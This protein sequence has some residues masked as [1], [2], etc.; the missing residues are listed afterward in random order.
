MHKVVLPILLV[1]AISMTAVAQEAEAA[2]D[3]GVAGI[4]PT[5]MYISSDAGE[6]AKVE[7]G[8]PGIGDTCIVGEF[9]E[10][11]VGPLQFCTDVALDITSLSV[12]GTPELY[13]ITFTD[14]WKVD[15]LSGD[16]T[17]VG[18]LLDGIV[19]STSM[20]AL[21][22]DFGGIAYATSFSG[23][24]YQVDLTDG[25]LSFLK[26]LGSLHGTT[27]P[28]SGDLAWDSSTGKMYWTSTHCDADGL[29][30]SAPALCAGGVDGLWLI[31]LVGPF[32]AGY[33]VND[34][35]FIADLLHADV[36]AADFIPGS[37]NICYVNSAGTL[38]ETNTSG[39]QQ[40]AMATSPVVGAF[41][42][43]AN[44][45]LV[46]GIAIALDAVAM[47]I[48]GIQTSSIWMAPLVFAGIGFVAYKLRSKN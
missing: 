15:Q 38:F 24:F 39:V 7:T 43:S 25:S 19:Q 29:G 4:T 5:Q 27:L 33:A 3:C 13:C 28:S 36:F 10:A 14:L 34:P 31:H 9:R 32:P 47:V 26:N 17:F 22:I 35:E 16:L 42:G 40:K 23:N 44:T 18:N 12:Y 48:S 37:G 45:A 30:G 46:G 8:M 11:G 2:P 20:N 6:L 21:E 41:G 1:M